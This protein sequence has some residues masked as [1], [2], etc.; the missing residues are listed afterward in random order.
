MTM[1]RHGK[2]LQNF[3]LWNQEA[4]D[5][6]TWYTA[7]GTGV[8]PFFQMM[9]LLGWPLPF[10]WWGQIYFL[11]LLHGESLIYRIHFMYFQVCSNSAY[12]QHSGE[13]YRI[14]GPLVIFVFFKEACQSMVQK[15]YIVNLQQLMF[16]ILRQN[17]TQINQVSPFWG[18]SNNFHIRN[19][20]YRADQLGFFN[21]SRSLV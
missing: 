19:C 11:M 4:D 14:I 8:L 17:C 6:E 16:M 12:P 3:L 10:L 5:F 20:S 21:A 15:W 7:S 1:P 18:Q 2:K 13:R 9:T